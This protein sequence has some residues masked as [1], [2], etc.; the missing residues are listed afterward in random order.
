MLYLRRICDAIYSECNEEMPEWLVVRL[1]FGVKNQLE[2][3]YN[4]FDFCGQK[5]REVSYSDLL[6]FDSIPLVWTYH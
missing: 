6:D 2:I 1:N 5:G 3:V 4:S